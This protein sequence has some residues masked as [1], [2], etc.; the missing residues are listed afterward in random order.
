M[1]SLC[2]CMFVSTVF[3]TLT[4]FASVTV[5]GSVY[6]HAL[7]FAVESCI[8]FF[9]HSAFWQWL[10]HYLCGSVSLSFIF[11]HCLRF[12]FVYCALSLPKLICA[13]FVALIVFCYFSMVSFLQHFIV[14]S[15]RRYDSN[16]A[17]KHELFIT[18][19]YVLQNVLLH[20]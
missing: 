20:T 1:I 13:M 17:G 16:F 19:Y 18:F 6:C 10:L 15:M 5:F 14:Y 2:D 11:L 8:F 7:F 3:P 4:V 12:W 9:L